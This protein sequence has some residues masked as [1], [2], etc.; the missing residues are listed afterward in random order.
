[1]PLFADTDSL[2]DSLARNLLDEL[3]VA[4][5]TESD[6]MYHFREKV[7]LI[8]IAS[9]ATGTILVDPLSGVDPGPLGAV[10]ASPSVTKIFHGADFDITSMK[11][12]FGWSFSNVFDTALAARFLGWPSVGLAAVILRE[13]GHEIPKGPQTADWSVRPLPA[14]MLEYAAGDVNYLVEIYRRMVRY[15]QEAGRLRWVI[16]ESAAIADIHAASPLPAPADFLKAT[17]ACD[18][19]GSDLAILKRLFAAREA[20]ALKLDRPR[21]KVIGDDALVRMAISRPRSPAA[22]ER[23]RAVPRPVAS[24][25]EPWLAAIRDG[26]SD[27]PVEIPRLRRR[28]P[29]DP[30]VAESIDRLKKWRAGASG[31]LGLDPGLLLPQRLI[32]AIAAAFP[33]SIAELRQVPG[34]HAWR[35]DEFGAELLE[36]ISHSGHAG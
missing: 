18:L 35:C 26:L 16:E 23:I 27:P 8:Q 12:D 9:D 2:V 30:R 20:V 31:R 22:L 17:G 34:V 10:M 33:A 28:P 3:C 29:F 11:R 24:H 13:F 14:N 4:F 19:D 32:V 1:M 7:C 15:L 36:C 21:F 6:S 5:D 25:P